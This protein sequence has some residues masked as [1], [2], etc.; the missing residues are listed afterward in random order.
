MATQL[1]PRQREVLDLVAEGRTSKEIAMILGISESTV[2][3]HLAN[4]FERLGA[5]SRAEAVAISMRSAGSGHAPVSLAPARAHVSA[6]RFG[7][8]RLVAVALAIAVAGALLGG[9]AVATFHLGVPAPTEI[10]NASPASYPESSPTSGPA[11]GTQGD[12]IGDRS[13]TQAD[14]DSTSVPVLGSPAELVPAGVSAPTLPWLPAPNPPLP[15]LPVTPPPL[16]SLPLPTPP[17]PTP[18]LPLP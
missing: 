1:S 14:P 6:A 15:T 17:I 11:S 8:P 16:P 9:A 4:A 12:V 7:W 10:P 3:W 18:R 5:S 2:N 13:G